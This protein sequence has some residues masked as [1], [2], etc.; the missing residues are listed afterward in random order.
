MG[1]TSLERLRDMLG[2]QRAGEDRIV[3]AFDARHVHEPGRAADEGAA[4]EGELRHRLTAAFGERTGTIGETLAPFEG[5]AHQRVGLE[6]LKFLK[7]I[8]IRIG[9]VE[10]KHEA[11]RHQIVVEVIEERA[12]AGSVVER[13]AEGVLHKTRPVLRRPD[14][15]HLLDPHAELFRP[16]IPLHPMPNCCDSRSRSRLNLSSRILLRLPHPPPANSVYL[17]RSS[18]PR[19]NE[20]LRRPSLPTPMSPVATPTT[21]PSAPSSTSAAAKPGK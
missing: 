1:T 19:A 11:D 12:A 2:R 13:P 17:A 8:E 9:V 14:L 16:A 3:A 20:S 5:R 15:P 21:A 4:R 6:A 10:V 7:R 18:T